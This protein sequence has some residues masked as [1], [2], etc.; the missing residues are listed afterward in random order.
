[1]SLPL[2]ETDERQYA[3]V[4]DNNVDR[5]RIGLRDSGVSPR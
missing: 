5:K 1:M 4:E 3:W 2:A